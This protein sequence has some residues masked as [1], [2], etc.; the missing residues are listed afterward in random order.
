[1]C[2]M[3]AAQD[4]PA[5]LDFAVVAREEEFDTTMFQ[6]APSLAK[7]VISVTVAEASDADAGVIDSAEKDRRGSLASGPVVQLQIN[8]GAAGTWPRPVFHDLCGRQF[9]Y[10]FGK[11]EA[12]CEL[13]VR[14]AYVANPFRQFQACRFQSTG[15]HVLRSQ[16]W[17]ICAVSVIII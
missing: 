14:D 15:Y 3:S 5:D 17:S 2:A 16:G 6:R 12:S 13:S 11:R 1:M 7:Y 4:A 10:A 8:A 9:G